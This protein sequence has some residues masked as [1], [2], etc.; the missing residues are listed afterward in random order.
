MIEQVPVP[1][2][3]R[4]TLIAIR[5]QL[6]FDD[7]FGLFEKHGFDVEVWEAGEVSFT[8]FEQRCM[9][10]PPWGVVAINYSP[11]LALLTSLFG[12]PYISWTI[13]PLPAHRV[14]VREGTKPELSLAFVHRADTK[15]RL[16]ELGLTDVRSLPLAAPVERRQRIEDAS[17]LTRYQAPVSFV[18]NSL[19]DDA[20]DL[21]GVLGR[22]GVEQSEMVKIEAALGEVFARSGENQ[23]YQG[24][25]SLEGIMALGQ[26]RGGVTER[27]GAYLLDAINGYISERLRYCRVEALAAMGLEVWGDSGWRRTKAKYRGP[28]EHGDELTRIYCAS[29]INLDIPRIYQRDILTMRVFDVLACGAVL[30]TESSPLLEEHFVVGEHLYTYSD[31]A[32][33]VVQV[34]KILANPDEAR[35]VANAGEQHVRANHRMEQRFGVIL[36][37]CVQRGWL[38]S[39]H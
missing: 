31:T 17:L 30:L 2:E 24:E 8:R 7:L 33:M 18:G 21:R 11:E 20:K 27:D 12:I 29:Q 26:L 23:A 19:E 22:L 6:I 37:A 35:A 3:G 28:A 36:E 4:P 9:E 39:L 25:A 34:E 16:E 1:P 13:D 5:Y 32:D 15:R 10:L 38:R 14:R